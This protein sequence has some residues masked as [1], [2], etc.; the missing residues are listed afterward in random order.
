MTSCEV[1]KPSKKWM[2]GTRDS[3]VAACAISAKSCASWTDADASIAQPVCARGH[4]I[5]VV[6]EDGQGLRGDRASRDMK[7]GRRQLA[8][9]LVHVGDHQQQ[10]LRR[11]KRRRQRAGLQCAVDRAG[12]AAFALHLDNLGHGAPDVR[13]CSAVHWS[14]HSPIVDDGVI[15]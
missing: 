3:S 6:A 7:D 12:G 10:A 13:L 14:A 4:D 1:R 5:R 15:G 9:D 11:G 8:R 2:N